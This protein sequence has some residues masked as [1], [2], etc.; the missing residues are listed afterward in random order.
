[1]ATT[2]EMNRSAWPLLVEAAR[3]KEL[4]TYTD[5]AREVNRL[6]G[7]NYLPLRI[8]EFALDRIAKWCLR[9]HVPD[10]TALAVSKETGLPGKDFFTLNRIDKTASVGSQRYQWAQIRDRVYAYPY[11][12]EP[13]DD[14]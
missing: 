3:R 13:P 12:L 10:L 1:M 14:L 2:L 5:L 6:F 7:A 11:P 8:G 4:L 9:N